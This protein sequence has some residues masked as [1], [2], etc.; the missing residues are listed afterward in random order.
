VLFPVL[1]VEHLS[2]EIAGRTVLHD[3]R[4]APGEVHFGPNGSGSRTAYIKAFIDNVDWR[5]VARR[6]VDAIW[7]SPARQGC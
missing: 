7:L 1:H 3:A 4:P 2:V 6:F 5:I